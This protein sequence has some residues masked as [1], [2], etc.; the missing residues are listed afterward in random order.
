MA[1]GGEAAAGLGER[2]GAEVADGGVVRG[3]GAA[4]PAQAVAAAAAGTA[5]EEE[6]MAVG[7]VAAAGLGERAGAVVADGG[8]A[9]GQGGGAA[10]RDRG[11]AGRRPVHRQR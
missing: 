1:V 7:G 3:Q 8:G 11:R 2:A 4:R 5:P 10:E 9:R 6:R